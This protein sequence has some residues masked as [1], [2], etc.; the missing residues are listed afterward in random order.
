MEAQCRN[1]LHYTSVW[2]EAFGELAFEQHTCALE[3]WVFPWSIFQVYMVW[4]VVRGL[5]YSKHVALPLKQWVVHNMQHWSE[6]SFKIYEIC[7]ITEEGQ[8]KT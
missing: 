1:V 3:S 5:F 7:D 2:H 4:E 8:S 6:D